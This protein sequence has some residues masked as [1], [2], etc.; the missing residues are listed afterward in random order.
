VIGDVFIQ[1]SAIEKLV[2]KTTSNVGKVISYTPKRTLSMVFK[3]AGIVNTVRD[4]IRVVDGAVKA[5][6]DF[7]GYNSPIKPPQE[8]FLDLMEQLHESK[9]L[10][11]IDMPYRT[12]KDMRITDLSVTKNMDSRALSFSM[13][14]QKIRIAKPVYTA[15]AGL[16]PQP[17]KSVQVSAK[18]NQ[19]AQ[20]GKPPSSSVLKSIA[21][22]AK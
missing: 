14:A 17:S 1:K 5:G 19:G 21:G 13:T 20:A 7:L 12:Y 6:R 22:L 10:V 8:S 3:M 16:K 11:K 18:K 2:N 9:S 4:K 15:S